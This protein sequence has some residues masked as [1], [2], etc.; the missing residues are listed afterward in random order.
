MD[1]KWLAEAWDW[2]K[3]IALA[4]IV[5]LIIHQFLFNLST[6]KGQSMEPTLEE[7]E[8]LFIDKFSYLIGTPKLHD[9]VILKNSSEYTEKR[10]FL[11]KR[12]VALPGDTVEIRNKE[13]FVNGIPA[14]ES[15]IDTPIEDGDL[16]PLV[17]PAEHYYVMGDNRHQDESKDSRSFGA[18]PSDRIKGKAQFILW[19]VKQWKKL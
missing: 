13:L 2:L 11:V 10:L 7:K 4:L 9:V 17:V 19:P 3:S 15:Y 16:G 8:W 6:V 12:I 18:V 5:V 14:V 1:S